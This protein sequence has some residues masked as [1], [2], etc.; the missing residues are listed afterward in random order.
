MAIEPKSLPFDKEL[1][2]ISKQTIDAHYEKLY[3]GY[4]N[5][6]NE[7]GPMLGQ[8]FL[9]QSTSEL[10][11]AN[12]TYSH[13]RA[14]RKAET[15]AMNGTFLHERYFECLGGNGEP[16]GELVDALAKKFGSLETFIKYFSASAMAM[17]GWAVLAWNTFEGKINVIGCD[18][19]D[20]GA[21]WGF[22]PI[23]VL[24]VYEHAY[25]IDY[26]TD[27]KSYIEAFWNNFNWEKANSIYNQVKEIKI[28]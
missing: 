14:L 24:D 8:T 17:R 26:G 18:S 10:D 2:G 3:K 22:I 6:R 5:K 25:F 15:F 7:I 27:R 1:V 11:R 19:H 4:V 16:A 12:Q 23:I 20:S 28:I 9:D 21:V 13:L